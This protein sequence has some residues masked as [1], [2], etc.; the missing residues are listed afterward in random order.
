M[1]NGYIGKIIVYRYMYI[2]KISRK[3]KLVF[4]I[5]FAGIATSVYTFKQR[6]LLNNNM[7]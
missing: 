7:W 3:L 2:V 5:V 6:I 1:H 4:E